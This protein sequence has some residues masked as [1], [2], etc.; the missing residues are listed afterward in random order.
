MMLP[1]Y[2][3]SEL[4]K[5]GGRSSGRR[6][7]SGAT[8]G[9]QPTQNT[10]ACPCFPYPSG[11]P[12]MGH[13]RNYTY[14]RCSVQISPY[15][16]LRGN[17]A[18]GWDASPARENAAMA[19]AC[20][21]RNG[22]TTTSL[23]EGSL[24]S[25]GF[26]IDWEREL[27]TCRPNIPWNQWLF[28]RMRKRPG[29]QTTGR[30]ELGSGRSDRTGQRQVIDGRGGAPV[31]SI[32]KREIPSTTCASRVMPTSC[33]RRWIVARLARARQADAGQLDRPQ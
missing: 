18:M 7:S 2:R 15:A 11:K 28:L 32:E 17:A 4:E 27:A 24:M 30:G 20:R 14:R 16:G 29:V 23:Y 12:H 25:L 9:C 1:Q 8:G 26:A 31:R 21:L 33:S 3:P 5:A 22:P 10:T 6:L 13:V 19:N